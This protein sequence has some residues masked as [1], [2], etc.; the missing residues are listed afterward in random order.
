[1]DRTIPKK[2]LM[3]VGLILITYILVW[4]LLEITTVPVFKGNLNF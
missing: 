3:I 4:L 2:K 1:M